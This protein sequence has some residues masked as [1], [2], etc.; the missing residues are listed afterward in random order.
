MRAFL[1][2]PIRVR[3]KVFGN[4][5]LT[6]KAGGVS[7]TRDDEDLAVALAAAA[8]A[9]VHNA[10]LYEET[11]RRER[12]L[13]AL[14]DVGYG[15]LR[16][17]PPEE[18]LHG[19]ADR[20]RALAEADV[21]TIVLPDATGRQLVIEV[22]VGLGADGLKGVAFT[23]GESL[24]GE[25]IR[26]GEGIVLDDAS[27]ASQAFQP[28]IAAAGL[29]PCVVV[30]LLREGRPAGTL[31]VGNQLGRRQF[32]DADL[33]LVET[34][35]A[36][37][38][39]VLE[40]ARA[41]REIQRLA[42]V[43]DQ[44]RIARDLHDT[45]IQQL[46]ATGMSLQAASRSVTDPLVVERIQGAVDD[47]DRTIKDIRSTIFALQTRSTRRVRDEVLAVT[48][49]AAQALGFDPHVRFSGAVDA[50]VDAEVAAHLLST[51]REAL[52]NVARHAAATR[53]DVEVTASPDSVLL[54][55][56]DDGIGIPPDPA[57][58]SGLRNMA[59]RADALGGKFGA[60]RRPDGGTS[61]EWR[62]PLPT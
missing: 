45:V 55:V 21:A 16:G 18:V 20:A 29:G 41:Q 61:V 42:I 44:E 35:A 37:A 10:R 27:A 14:R 13:E 36:Q 62:V 49:E 25:V 51:L 38:S 11:Q 4:L 43:A 19:V 40:Y 7:F 9:A 57:R 15:L 54:T 34:F 3:G 39:V 23:A 22:A 26:S 8:G 24:S 52:S 28:A 60:E 30:P 47:L 50:L 6:E 12:L 53:V 46:F 5:Y 56:A 48:S 58:R 31:L 17:Q 32:T 2:V 59:E 33:A 1:G